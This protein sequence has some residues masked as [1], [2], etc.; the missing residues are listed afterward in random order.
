M[1]QVTTIDEAASVPKPTRLTL[2]C[3]GCTG[4]FPTEQSFDGDSFITQYRLAMKA[5]WKDTFLRGT[6]VHYGPCCSGKSAN[7]SRKHND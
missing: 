4:M 2:F 5:G 1:L 3:D 6:R 7:G